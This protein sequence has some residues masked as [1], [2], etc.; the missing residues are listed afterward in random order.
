M[1]MRKLRIDANFIQLEELLRLL[2]ILNDE[3]QLDYEA[4][5]N[6]FNYHLPYPEL[7]KIQGE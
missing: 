5:L 1:L 3:D 6:I 7:E 4:F 2:N